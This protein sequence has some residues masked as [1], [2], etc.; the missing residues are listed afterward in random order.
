[1]TSSNKLKPIRRG[2]THQWIINLNGVDITN[3]IF[4]VVLKED[5]DDLNS[6][7]VATISATS[8]PANN[9]LDDPIN[10]IIYMTLPASISSKLSVGEH[11]IGMS[12]ETP[13]TPEN[14]IKTILVEKI[15]VLPDVYQN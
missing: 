4:V 3:V 15:D 14:I 5:I 12:M 11:Y 2:D 1:M 7:A 13:A 6:R 9:V 8:G 10:G